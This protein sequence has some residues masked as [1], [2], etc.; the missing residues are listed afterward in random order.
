MGIRRIAAPLAVA[1]AALA[2]ASAPAVAAIPASGTIIEGIG[3]SAVPIGTPVGVAKAK[4]GLVCPRPSGGTSST[5]CYS[6]LNRAINWLDV[7]GARRIETLVWGE[8]GWRTRRG[9]GLGSRIAAAK[10]AYGRSLHVRANATWTY[11]TLRRT[12]RGEVRVTGFTGRTKVGDIVQIYVTRE[13]RR[14]LRVEPAAVAAGAGFAGVMTDWSPRQIYDAE[15]RMPWD[16]GFGADLSRIRTKADGS[17]RLAVGATGVLAGVLARRPAGTTAPVTAW[18]IVGG[19]SGRTVRFTLG[20]PP[21]PTIALTSGT[22]PPDG[23]VTLSVNG[24]EPAGQYEVDAEWTC[25]AT[26]AKGRVQ[27]LQDDPIGTPAGGSLSGALDTSS[28]TYALFDEAC[29]GGSPPAT[30]PATLVLLRFG[31][32]RGGSTTRERVATLPVT[33]SRI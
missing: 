24:A 29:A 1:A 3:T 21:P 19:R 9:I 18:L 6:S 11:M 12:V 27:S 7:N 30:L 5:R 4:W 17:A 31:E 26:G 28:V 8:G 14:L 15:L 10:A 20:L 13:R 16:Q 33:V 2:V 23:A 22:L 32:S 25:P